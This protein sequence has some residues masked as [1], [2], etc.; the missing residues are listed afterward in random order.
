MEADFSCGEGVCV[1]AILTFPR[2]KMKTKQ[3]NFQEILQKFECFIY[4]KS[5]Y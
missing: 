2:K 1:Q 4:M 3:N 5:V